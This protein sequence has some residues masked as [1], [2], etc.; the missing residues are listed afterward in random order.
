MKPTRCLRASADKKD[1]RLRAWRASL[2]DDRPLLA[3]DRKRPTKATRSTSV[4]SFKLLDKD[5][6]GD[7]KSL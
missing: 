6:Y 4:S 2:A 1:A 7:V 3:D 5:V